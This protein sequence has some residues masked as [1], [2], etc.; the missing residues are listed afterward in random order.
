MGKNFESL[1]D[2]L[3][4]LDQEGVNILLQRLSVKH[5]EKCNYCRK[6]CEDPYI[7]FHNLSYECPSVYTTS[8]FPAGFIV[9]V[10]HFCEGCFNPLD[11]SRSKIASYHK[12][13]EI[14]Q[15]KSILEARYVLFQ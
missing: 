12:I 8:S 13:S 1:Q 14:F 11:K 2:I 3:Q 5:S 15:H 10:I 4:E 6:F 7:K 9:K